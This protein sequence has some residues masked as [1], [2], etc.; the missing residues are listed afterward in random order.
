MEKESCF[1]M[2]IEGP[3]EA[4]QVVRDVLDTSRLINSGLLTI[5]TDA[6]SNVFNDQIQ[7]QKLVA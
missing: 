2:T 7:V 5:E 3:G 4:F 1:Q 6:R